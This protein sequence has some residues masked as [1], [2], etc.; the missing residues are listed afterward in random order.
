MSSRYN[1]HR[2]F[3]IVAA[4]GAGKLLREDF[5]RENGPQGTRHHA[6]VDEETESVIYEVLTKN[7]P[8]FGYLEE[9]LG[10]KRPSVDPEKH[11]WLV[12]P[13]DGTSAFM[14]GFRGAAVSIALLRHGKPV[15]GVV[16][17]F[18]YP[19]DSGDLISWIQ[20]GPVIRND[21]ALYREW[22]SS[23]TQEQ[24]VLLPQSADK[25]PEANAQK[26]EPM[27]YRP[28][29]SIAYRLALVAVGDG[30][31]AIS[32]NGPTGWD[33]AA[34]HAILM[35]AGGDLFDADGKPLRYSSEGKSQ[36][37][38]YVFGGTWDLVRH[39]I[40]REWEYVFERPEKNRFHARNGRRP[41]ILVEG[42]LGSI[43]SGF[44]IFAR[45]DISMVQGG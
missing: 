27:R 16:C 6:L 7:F 22:P 10:H 25:N 37:S 29:P 45:H 9:E 44:G 21:L 1:T 38:A 18:N 4:K 12:D 36:H 14:Q 41:V 32:L 33:C 30:D 17:A 5:H 11:L 8:E 39:L 31:V 43:E 35:G 24:T 26:V 34:G 42:C 28:V 13:N 20:D 19:D 15:L 2:E 3:A 40:N 23:P